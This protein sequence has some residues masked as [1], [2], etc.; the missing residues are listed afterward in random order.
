MSLAIH[1]LGRP[2]LERDGERVARPRGH[3][4]WGLVAYLVLSRVSR[5]SREH[6]AELL[7]T[8]AD[9]PL[10]SLRWNLAE[11]RRALGP[12]TLPRGSTELALLPG[13]FVD[14]DA[15]IR[16][17]PQEAVAI[18]G[19]GSELLEGMEFGNSPAFETWL[20]SERRRLL[21][22]AEAALH[23]AALDRLAAGEA[24]AAA[25][26]AARLVELNPYDE[27]FQELLVRSYSE[28]GDRE[29]ANR[30]VAACVELFRAEHGRDPGA[31]LFR[32]AQ[33]TPP[34]PVPAGAG[35]KQAARARLEA[36]GSAIHAGSF[37]PG[38]RSLARAAAE[39]KA[40][41]A[42][43]LEAESWLALGTALV[44]SARG[45]DEEGANALLRATW[46][47]EEHGLGDLAA[48]AHRELAYVDILQA[49]YARCAQ[50]LERAGALADSDEERAGVEAMLGLAAADTG[51]HERALAHLWLSVELAERAGSRQQASFSLSFVGRSLFLR[52][53]LDAARAALERSL[54]L[55]RE[56]KW[57]AFE[58]W[59]ES[60]LAEADLASG[61]LPAGRERFEHAWALA[62]E[63]GDPCWE[64]AAGQGLGRIACLEGK[65]PTGLRMLE[66]ARRRAGSF[67]DTYV[68]VEAYALAELASAAVAA[69]HRR[70]REW[71]E[72]LTSLAARTGMREFAVR[73]YLL[74][75]DLGDRSALDSAAILAAEVENPALWGRIQDLRA[76]VAA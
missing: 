31:A 2:H 10:G 32:A 21:G 6:L 7:F 1:L 57:V 49:R 56:S 58:P 42:H 74:R 36:G 13:T 51:A 5:P 30:Q 16:G 59:P 28:A 61:E 47:A 41:G 72:D 27:N 35:G 12:A 70:A 20:L 75:A 24:A 26:V 23:E 52:E 45:R 53:E 14:V 8:G 69:Q 29:A 63:L 17:T 46:L 50:R 55:A 4:A 15:L 22:A 48:A 43:E 39:A 67:A 60:W 40:C 76:A 37:D 9:D 38:V 3:K 33:A 11:L 54:A 18:P 66:E 65:V 19:L 34:A 25:R 71:V 62:S 44:H 64:G 73:A 68:W